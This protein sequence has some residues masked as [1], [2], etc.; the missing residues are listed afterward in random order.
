MHPETV[1]T[2]GGGYRCPNSKPPPGLEAQ[3][4]DEEAVKISA[5]K[6]PARA[7]TRRYKRLRVGLTRHHLVG[8]WERVDAPMTGGF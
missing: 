7:H 3:E 5:Q 4:R 8:A 1:W 6:D 2:C